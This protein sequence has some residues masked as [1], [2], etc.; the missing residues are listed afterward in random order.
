MRFTSLS[1]IVN[2]SFRAAEVK[3]SPHTVCGPPP[4]TSVYRFSRA[5]SFGLTVSP[6][7]SY[8]DYNNNTSAVYN[9][10]R[11]ES[12]DVAATLVL[13]VPCHHIPNPSPL[14]S[15]HYRSPPLSL[16]RPSLPHS[17]TKT[18][19]V[20][21][22]K[23]ESARAHFCCYSRESELVNPSSALHGVESTKTFARFSSQRCVN[24][25]MLFCSIA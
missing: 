17:I 6:H 9:S 8:Y 22:R 12:Q 21:A 14:L 23:N 7:E 2:R 25:A 11:K 4:T 18:F 20:V 3:S 19:G 13:V 10:Y 16:V 5:H 24:P 1:M 15:S